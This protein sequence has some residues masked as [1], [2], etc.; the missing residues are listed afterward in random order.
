MAYALF[1]IF[2]PIIPPMA[3]TTAVKPKSAIRPRPSEK[4]PAR[5][6][7]ITKASRV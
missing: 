4:V 6:E 2:T 5:Q 7:K 3:P 1:L